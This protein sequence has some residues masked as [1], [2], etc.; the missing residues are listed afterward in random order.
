MDAILGTHRIDP[1][2]LRDDDFEAFFERRKE[3]L[4]GIVEEAMG[5][6]I[7]REVEDRAWDDFEEEPLLER[8]SA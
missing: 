1:D 7:E 3:S 2:A 4:L 8:A 6:S 5:K